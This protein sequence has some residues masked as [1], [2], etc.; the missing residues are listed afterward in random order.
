M[1]TFKLSNMTKGWFVGNFCPSSFKTELFEV[2]VVSHPKDSKWD[3]HYHKKA[4]E[5]TLILEGKMKMHDKEFVKGDIFILHPYEIANPCFLE[6]TKVVVIK[7]PSVPA[8]KYIV[9]GPEGIK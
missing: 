7:T 2:A 5:I 8:D 9:S 3:V 1:E 4:T 6:D